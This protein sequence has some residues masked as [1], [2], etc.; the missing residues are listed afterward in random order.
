MTAEKW[1][2][3]IGGT[4]ILGVSGWALLAQLIWGSDDEDADE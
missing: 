1:I 2:M 3:L 4:V